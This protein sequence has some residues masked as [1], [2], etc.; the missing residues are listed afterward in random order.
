MHPDQQPAVSPEA[1]EDSNAKA[2]RGEDEVAQ[3]LDVPAAD[4]DS[5]ALSPLAVRVRGAIILAACT[6]VLAVGAC[7][8]PDPTGMGTHEQL[9]IPACSWP[10]KYG[11]PCPTC[12][13]TTAVTAAVHGQWLTAWNAQPMGLA[14]ALAAAV[15]GVLAL[16]EI[17]RGRAI[18]SLLRPRWMWAVAFVVATLL[19]WAWKVGLGL[20]YGRLPLHY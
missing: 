1:D 6:A 16:L 15:G 14:L 19:G 5:P 17:V 2:Q 18:G 4:E 13:A 9:G 7:L 12:G 3:A 20:L 10:M 11:Y 8:T